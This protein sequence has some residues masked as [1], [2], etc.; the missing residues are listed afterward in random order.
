M[1]DAAEMI[2]V[3]HLSELFISTGMSAVVVIL[4]QLV[5]SMFAIE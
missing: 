2:E 5:S 1:V 4:C 3:V